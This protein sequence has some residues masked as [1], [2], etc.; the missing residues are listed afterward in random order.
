MFLKVFK[1]DFKALIYKY[2]PVLAILPV[3]AVIVRLVNLIGYDDNVFFLLLKM[4]VNGFFILGCCFI[5]I[6]TIVICIVRYAKSL[7]K[8]Q[9]Y[10]THTLPV[11][12]HSLLLSH[13]LADFLMQIISFLVLMV[14]CVIAYLNSMLWEVLIQAFQEMFKVAMTEEEIIRLL[15]GPTILMLLCMLFSSF[16]SLFVIYTGIAIGHAFAKNKGILSVIFCIA[17]NYAIGIGLTIVISLYGLLSRNFYFETP[18]DIINYLNGYL[19]IILAICIVICLVGYFVDIY[20][21]Q[22][23]LNLE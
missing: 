4:G 20:L 2:L 21:M 3:L 9:G 7:F 10:L 12:K 17:L 1:Y 19:G 22:K 5:S 8:D 23:K 13:L 14:C 11:T 6:Y 15:A 18:Q 16:Q